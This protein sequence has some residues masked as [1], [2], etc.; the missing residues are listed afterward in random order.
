MKTRILIAAACL[1][2][3]ALG[4]TQVTPQRLDDQAQGYARLGQ[5]N[6]SVVVA[7]DGRT[8]LAKGYGMANREWEI[9]NAADTKFR[10]GSITKQFTGMAVLML[11]QQGKL[12]VSDPVCSYVE[13][14][15]Q[16][17]KPI[18]IHHLLTHTSG[19]P[20]FTGFPDYQKTMM[21][22][23]PPAETLKRFRDK[24]LEFDPGTKHKYSNSGYVLLG[25]I[26][27]KAAGQS[28]AAYIKQQIFTPLGMNDTGYDSPAEVLPKRAAGY[29]RA[30]SKLENAAYLDMSIPHAAGSMY[31]TAL[32]LM[33][34]DVA[35]RQGKLLTP[36]NY[37]RY[38]KP[39]IGDYAYGWNVQKR[40][41]VEVISHGG[42]INGF[43]TTILRVPERKLVV[44]ALSNLEQS[45]VGRLGQDLLALALGR[46]VE[47]PKAAAEV[48]V[49][50]ETLK[51]YV[52]E[53][54]LSPAFILT[55]TL[56]G[57][58]LITQA[59]GQGKIAI[60]A[61]DEA[62]FAPREFAAEIVF[63]RDASGKV[64]GLVLNQGG[65][66]MPATRR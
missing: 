58:T 22:A 14:C 47:T 6:G 41:G 56:E 59:T 13:A 36:E 3:A 63:Q 35:L 39:G 25:H 11:E 62:T 51:Q 37:Q 38:F 27:E 12:K 43:S 49:P 65:R 24:P 16:T 18:T 2:M 53:Y 31:S 26:I 10:L 52:G 7:V 50:V 17:W 54:V 29:T 1:S 5:F 55:V 45:Q 19:I 61:K 44:V 64:T 20:N 48:K 60:Y 57:D 33:L 30:G 32:D 9:A 21:L 23:S 4:Q 34:W 46:E 15:P 42:G 28:Y 8:L 40:N 66:K